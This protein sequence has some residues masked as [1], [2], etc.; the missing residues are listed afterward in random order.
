MD[1]HTEV[2]RERNRALLEVA[3]FWKRRA[4][5]LERRLHEGGIDLSEVEMEQLG[6]A[7]RDELS[8]VL[9]RQENQRAKAAN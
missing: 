6:N 3:R 7:L 8:A 2:L 5:F 1:H 9:E 4:K